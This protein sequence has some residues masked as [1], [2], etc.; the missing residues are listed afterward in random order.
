MDLSVCGSEAPKCSPP[1]SERFKNINNRKTKSASKQPL[2]LKDSKQDERFYCRPA[3][4]PSLDLGYLQESENKVK[5]LPNLSNYELDSSVSVSTID[6]KSASNSEYDNKLWEY[7]SKSSSGPHP[8]V[9]SL[10]LDIKETPHIPDKVKEDVW[11]NAVVPEDL[12]GPSMKYRHMYKQYQDELKNSYRKSKGQVNKSVVA[13][14]CENGDHK[15]GVNNEDALLEQSLAQLKLLAPSGT[16]NKLEVEKSENNKKKE[17]LIETVM[18]DQL[19]RSVICDPEQNKYSAEPHTYMAHQPR[20]ANRFL[21]ESSIQT[22]GSSTENL[23][24]KRV[25]FGVRILTRNGHDALRELIG[26]FFY[27]DNTLTI[28][29]FRQFGKSSKALP[30]IKKGHYCPPEKNTPSQHYTLCNIYPG[31]NLVLS[32][33]NQTCLPDTLK[34]KPKV[35]FRVTDVAEKEKSAVLLSGVR[36]SDQQQVYTKLHIPQHEIDRQKMMFLAEVQ[37]TVHHK[38]KKRGIRT[39]T[40]LGQHYRKVCHRLSATDGCLSKS[41]LEEGL[42]EFHIDLPQTTLDKLF[43]AI[44]DKDRDYLDYY[45][46]MLAVIGEMNEFR[47]DFVRKT[48][49]K[50]GGAKKGS[51]S[52]GEIR[53]FYHA[54]NQTKVI[55][56][57]TFYDAF[58]L[59]LGVC[60]KS[61]KESEILEYLEWEEYYDGLSI[62]IES[63]QE[64]VNI[65]KNLWCV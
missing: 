31:S 59:M 65:F 15:S 52:V 57:D 11:D 54:G 35:I 55:S 38:L 10:G 16:E 60:K 61:T 50:M 37:Q 40:G 28:Y 6:C 1:Q 41:D 30:F 53:K 27:V 24:S 3:H 42:R 8:D 33:E 25:R 14:S 12:P 23:L 49:Q 13:K 29:E 48:Y 58:E 17:K 19:S 9:P 44:T 22:H 5:L 64:F 62:G 18:I 36:L 26:F 43:E 56:G 45:L 20:G 32:T 4:V 63:D 39:V 47:K 34:N 51:I 7:I 21:H 46:Y 2:T